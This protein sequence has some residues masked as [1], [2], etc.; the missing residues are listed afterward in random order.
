MIPNLALWGNIGAA[1]ARCTLLF[2]QP[3]VSNTEYTFHKIND[4]KQ[5][6]SKAVF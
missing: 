1:G 6:K 5:N 3:T 4:E 2:T